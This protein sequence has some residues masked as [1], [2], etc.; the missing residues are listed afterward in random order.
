MRHLN[1]S[2]L[3]Y[4]WHV[5][6]EG[7]IASASKVL[8]LTPQTISGQLK[9]LEESI[10]EPLFNRVGR[11][12]VLSETGHLVNQYADEIFSLGAELA[13]RVRGKSAASPLTLNVGVVN[14]IAKLIAFHLL[15]PALTMKDNFRV[16][17]HEGDLEDLLADL[18]I[19]RLD[20]VLSDRPIPPGLGV[21]AYNHP[22]GQSNVAFFCAPSEHGQYRKNFPECLDGA[23][24]LLP[25]SDNPVRRQLDD[26]FGS[27]DISPNIIAEFDDSA[28][29]KVFGGSE[30]GVFPAPEAISSHIEKMYNVR[31]FG[32]ADGVVENFYAISPERKVRHPAVALIGQRA[33]VEFLN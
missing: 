23:P 13:N 21:K 32:R 17:C 33:K 30:V 8:H 5:A 16:Q 18:S 26:W 2:H 27:M 15:A 1:Y 25:L 20:I 10:G 7:S 19:H 29:M 12:L 31:Q 9:L 4:F 6:R 3:Y 14:S 22:L 24:M 28:L 11:S